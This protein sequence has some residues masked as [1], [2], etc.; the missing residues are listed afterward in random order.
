MNKKYKRLKK[1]KGA[2]Y[3]YSIYWLSETSQ[4]KKKPYE[5]HK[6]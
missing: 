2:D 5:A 1:R 4:I 6:D 3:M